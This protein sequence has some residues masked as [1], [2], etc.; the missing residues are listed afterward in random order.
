MG[1][2]HV[3]CLPAL[4]AMAIRLP[5]GIVA[6]VLRNAASEV[7]TATL[8]PIASAIRMPEVFT[9][10]VIIACSIT[11]MKIAHGDHQLIVALLLRNMK[12]PLLSFL[13]MAMQ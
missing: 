13:I 1:V 8:I 3:G 12:S 11:H 9:V 4:V 6:P 10:V 5:I 7:V 2:R